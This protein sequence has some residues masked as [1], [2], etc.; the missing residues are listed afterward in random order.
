[1]FRLK[2][3]LWW[4]AVLAISTAATAE[5]V[6]I[7]DA[8]G[9]PMGRLPIIMR[10]DE[11][12]IPLAM[13]ARK[14]NW[15][16]SMDDQTYSISAGMREVQLRRGNPFVIVDG[17]YVQTSFAP[18]EWDGS[19]WIPLSNLFALFGDQI[20]RDKL[21]GALSI[22]VIESPPPAAAPGKGGKSTSKAGEDQWALKT[23]IIDAGH[24]GKDPGARGLYGLEEKV[25]ALDVAK[26]LR[27]FLQDS[28]VTVIL[29]RDDDRFLELHERTKF[30][31]A[32]RGDMFLSIHCNSFKDPNIG[33]IETYF[34]KPAKSERAVE[35]AMRE[36]S[37]V[38]LESDTSMYQDLT[39]ENYILLSMATS[40]F[41]KDS[42]TWAASALR[43]LSEKTSMESRQVDQAG[44]YVL[45]GASMPAILVEC[46][47]LSNPDDAKLLASE[48]GR[49]KLAEAL[50]SSIVKMKQ[51]LETSASR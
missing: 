28:G 21:T 22:Q 41:M 24:G 20:A 27:A 35:A 10:G 18:E 5:S 13:L 49:I 19:L 40:Q 43:M 50:A 17:R 15:Q 4:A 6:M 2:Q 33:G 48:R 1:M 29:T 45:M 14:G 32:Q 23:I 12:L 3:W 34:L 11:S 37:V 8:N 44:F 26:R 46:G 30:A 47:Y 16:V 36:N 51:T 25:V 31:N 9:L 39:E 38:K 7:T 42:E